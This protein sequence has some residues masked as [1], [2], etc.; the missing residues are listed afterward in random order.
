MGWAGHEQ[1]KTIIK[2]KDATV[3][4]RSLQVCVCEKES[5]RESVCVCVCVNCLFLDLSLPPFPPSLLI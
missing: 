5:M 4:S 1:E 2:F 3:R